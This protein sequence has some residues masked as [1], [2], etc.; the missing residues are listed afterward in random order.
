M[1]RRSFLRHAALLGAVGFAPRAFA[2]SGQAEARFAAIGRKVGGRLGV[3]S[4]DTGSGWR[5]SY[6]ADERFA[7]CSTFKFLLVAAVLKKVDAG[8][9]QLDRRI[10]YGKGD[11]LPHAPVS[12][13]HVAEGA[14]P[15]SALC[16]AAIEYS[17][18]TAANLLLKQ[19]GGPDG[20]TR[21]ARLIGDP[22][23]RLDRTEMTLN[24]AIKGDPR[25]TT[26]PAAM[27]GDLRH[28]LLESVLSDA[29]RQQLQSW[30]IANKT[31]GERIRAGVPSGWRVG[32]KTG[33][34]ENGATN[35]IAILWPPN[36]API[37]VAAYLTETSAP[38]EARNAAHAEIG[39]IVVE[40]FA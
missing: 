16:E 11:L 23:T 39:R 34:G 33:T 10:A 37:L 29:S 32:D 2:D 27:L 12:S 40:A 19:I 35:D 13:A 38:L 6:R 3:A 17:D 15:L 28:V 25:D 7:M 1:K 21:F 36:R 26:T 9:A 20:V 30:L 22:V 8:E 31:G 24:T 5:V 18:N 14:L 4:L